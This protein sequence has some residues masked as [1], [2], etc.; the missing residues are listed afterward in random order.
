MTEHRVVTSKVDGRRERWRAHREAR[1]AELIDAVVAAVDRRGPG[2]GMDDISS[3]SSIAKPVFYRYFDDKADLFLAVGRRVAETVVNET[4]A[5]IDEAVQPRAKLAAGIDA[6]LAGIEANPEL[7]RFV[8]RHSG[9]GRSG[10][11][12]LLDDYATVV[13]LHASR[14]IG[15]LLR[16]A[17]LDAGPAELWGFGIVG[18]VRSVADRWLEQRQPMSR[19]AVVA[20]LTDLLWPGLTAGVPVS[21]GDVPPGGEPVSG[22]DRVP[23]EEP[24]LAGD[25]VPGEE[26]AAPGGEGGVPDGEPVR[27][28]PRSALG[29]FRP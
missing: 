26:A 27:T 8:V 28:E 21:G 1:R 17:G 3:A 10:E 24:A 29:G 7:Y 5:A 13:G 14:V 22:G 2:I 4:M 23:G 6:Y 18:L 9:E 20:Y 19:Q 25:R 15:D 11:D 12:D 16:E